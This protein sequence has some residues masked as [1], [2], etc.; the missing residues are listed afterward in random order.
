MSQR[1][2]LY[3]ILGVSPLASVETMKSSFQK[4]ALLHH[5]DKSKDPESAALFRNI[6][7][8]WKT[9]GDAEERAK[10]DLSIKSCDE[11]GVNAENVALA[12]FEVTV[13]NEEKC[14]KK[15]CRCGGEYEV[16]LSLSLRL[17]SN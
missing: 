7:D 8:A 6:H 10:Y 4:L 9:L 17:F 13:E 14:Y 2:D 12:E 15:S 3:A 5:P 16:C 11:V 1:A